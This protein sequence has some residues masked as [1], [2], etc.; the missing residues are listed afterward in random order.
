[1]AAAA[2]AVDHALE[3]AFR[4][5]NALFRHM[6]EQAQGQHPIQLF[7]GNAL[8]EDMAAHLDPAALPKPTE[9]RLRALLRQ[10]TDGKRAG[11]LKKVSVGCGDRWDDRVGN[12]GPARMEEE[13]GCFDVVRKA[14]WEAWLSLGSMSAAQARRAFINTIVE[15]GIARRFAGTARCPEADV[16]LVQACARDPLALPKSLSLPLE[17]ALAQLHRLDELQERCVRSGPHLPAHFSLLQPSN[18]QALLSRRQVRWAQEQLWSR[19]PVDP[20]GQCACDARAS[21]APRTDAAHHGWYAV[22]SDGQVSGRR[23]PT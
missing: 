7:F 19:V 9:L 22:A 2:A 16:G 20:N 1:M 13:P 6:Q 3:D 21:G 18:R 5:A 4:A 12:A 15:V 23:R 17:E 14:Q 11:H 10:A 8:V